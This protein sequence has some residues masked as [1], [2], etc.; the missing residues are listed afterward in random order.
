MYDPEGGRPRAV[1][2]LL[3][4]RSA[5]GFVF[6]IFDFKV[7]VQ[8]GLQKRF[9]GLGRLPRAD[10]FDRSPKSTCQMYQLSGVRSVR[11]LTIIAQLSHSLYFHVFA[12]KLTVSPLFSV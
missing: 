3:P 5:Y 1:C 7:N 6:S 12:F 10:K 8:F 11:S 2:L 4:G 9:G